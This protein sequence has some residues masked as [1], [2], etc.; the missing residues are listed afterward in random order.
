MKGKRE[1]GRKGKKEN[2]YKGRKENWDKERKRRNGKL[3]KEGKTAR[4]EWKWKGGEEGRKEGQSLFPRVTIN[5]H[6]QC[7]VCVL[8]G[9]VGWQVHTRLRCT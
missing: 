8:M 3:K 5:L 4:K 7:F 1:K 2:E 9:C 6:T